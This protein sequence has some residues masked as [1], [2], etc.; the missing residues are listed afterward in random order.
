M[1]SYRKSL[2]GA[3]LAALASYV[4]EAARGTLPSSAATAAAASAENAALFAS[5]AAAFS[6]YRR[7]VARVDSKL[8]LLDPP[9]LLKPSFDAERGALTRSLAICAKIEQAFA[10]HKAAAANSGIHA[11]YGT[12]AGLASSKIRKEQNAAIRVYDAQLKQMSRLNTR[13]AAERQK[14]VTEI[15]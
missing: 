1:P 6:P 11:L 5:Y 4:S 3:E 15:G 9:A 2:T 12:V 14:L 10:R 13:I 7:T 8:S